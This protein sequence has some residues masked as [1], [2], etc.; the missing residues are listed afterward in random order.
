M[1]SVGAIVSISPAEYNASY[2]PTVYFPA[3]KYTYTIS[4]YNNPLTVNT[5]V[6]ICGTTA[7]RAGTAGSFTTIR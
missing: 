7:P 2:Y 5:T 3:Q 1:N 4:T 6:R